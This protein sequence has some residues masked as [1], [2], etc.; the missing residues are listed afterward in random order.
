MGPNMQTHYITST[1]TADTGG[2]CLVDIINLQSGAC[3]VISEDTAILYYGG[4]EAF[5]ASL[6]GDIVEYKSLY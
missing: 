2:H 5:Y 4:K 1:E 3:I 6:D